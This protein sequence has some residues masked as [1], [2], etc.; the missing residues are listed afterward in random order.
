LVRGVF[1]RHN[2]Q[3]GYKVDNVKDFLGMGTLPRPEKKR[4]FGYTLGDFCQI[5]YCLA[6]L[7]ARLPCCDNSYRV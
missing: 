2:G 1:D 7:F 4:C 6:C 5:S 3:T